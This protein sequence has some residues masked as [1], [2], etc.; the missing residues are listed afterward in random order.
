[1]ERNQGVLALSLPQDPNGEDTSSNNNRSDDVSL[2]PFRLLTTSKGEWDE[3]EGD[4]SNKE[5]S[6]DD[7]ELPEK[8]RGKVLEAEL[9]EGGS[10]TCEGSC[11]GC[12]SAS[13][14]KD[15]DDAERGD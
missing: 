2:T 5:D 12:F 13:D 4:R 3:E 11:S 14:D 6:T 8:V 10:V 15:G 1:M 9:L 7:I